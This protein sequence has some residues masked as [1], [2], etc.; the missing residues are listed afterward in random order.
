MHGTEPNGFG[1]RSPRLPSRL[2]LRSAGARSNGRQR[3]QVG[4]NSGEGGIR[5][6]GTLSDTHDFQSCTFGHSVT[7]PTATLGPQNPIVGY[8]GGLSG[9]SGSRTHGTLAD[10]PDFESGTF[11]HSVISPRRTLAASLWACQRSRRF[12]GSQNRPFTPCRAHSR[13]RA[14]SGG[15]VLG[16]GPRQTGPPA[17]PERS[18]PHARRAPL[19]PRAPG[20]TS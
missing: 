6:L 1:L 18:R 5:T 4:N 17:P 2:A 12:L 3:D 16:S 9:E 13:R 20:T 8:D 11:G 14:R 19:A 7:S 10:T 15:P